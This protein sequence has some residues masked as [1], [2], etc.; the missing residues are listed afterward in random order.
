MKELYYREKILSLVDKVFVEIGDARS[1]IQ[2]CEDKIFTAYLASKMS[3]VPQ[4]VK[5]KWEVIW[6]ELNVESEWADRKGRQITSSLVATTRKKR[7]QTMQ[8][9]LTFF[10]EEFYRVL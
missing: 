8:K 10:L 3:G 4:E 7:N 1:R 9:Y 2:N 6:S 5:D